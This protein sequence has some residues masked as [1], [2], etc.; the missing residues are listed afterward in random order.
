MLLKTC[1]LEYYIKN[2]PEEDKKEVIYL[3]DSRS[4]LDFCSFNINAVKDF[5][6]MQPIPGDSFKTLEYKNA[7]YLYT[8][9]SLRFETIFS[10]INELFIKNYIEPIFP[11]PTDLEK[12]F[13]IREDMIMAMSY[14]RANEF[15]GVNDFRNFIPPKYS[16]K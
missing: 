12:C 10:R 4:E 1:K 9:C 14:Y 7:K 16:K 3:I 8:S 6:K 5:K 11:D 15:F 2:M 13:K